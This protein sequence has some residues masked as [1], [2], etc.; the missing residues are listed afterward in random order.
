MMVNHIFVR[1]RFFFW[2]HRRLFWPLSQKSLSLLGLSAIIE[3]SKEELLPNIENEVY[4]DEKTTWNCIDSCCS[5]SCHNGNGW[6]SKDRCEH[7]AYVPCSLICLLYT[8]KSLEKRLQG[9]CYLRLDRI[10]DRKW[11]LRS[12]AGLKWSSYHSRCARLPGS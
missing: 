8:L 7:L 2:P 6:F 5:C 11:D 12:L 9:K 4:D 10:Y 1:S 3:S